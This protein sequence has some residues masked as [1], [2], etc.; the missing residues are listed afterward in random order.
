V[1]AFV[2]VGL[3]DYEAPGFKSSDLLEIYTDADVAALASLPGQPRDFFLRKVERISS[4]TTDD[5]VVF[6]T[7]AQPFTLEAP[8]ITTDTI[9]EENEIDFD[10]I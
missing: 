5:D 10:E 6:S 9:T 2:M 7:A 8:D 4:A 1:G 3:H